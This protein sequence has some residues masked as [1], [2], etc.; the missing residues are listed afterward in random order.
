MSLTPQG[1]QHADPDH[2]E[3]TLLPDQ[4][5]FLR[6]VSL[7]M[8]LGRWKRFEVHDI[9]IECAKVSLDPKEASCEEGYVN[10]PER[11][12]PPLKLRYLDSTTSPYSDLHTSFGQASPTILGT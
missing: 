7:L 2:Q 12:H 1:E 9:V 6:T 10:I 8:L 5:H 11:S 3:S 4:S